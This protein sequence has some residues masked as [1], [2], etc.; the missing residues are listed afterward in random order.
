MKTLTVDDVMAMRPCPRWT[1]EQVKAVFAG[2]QEVAL[3]ALLADEAIPIGDRIWLALQPGVLPDAEVR[4]WLDGV[5]E[6]A[7]RANLGT[8]GCPKWETW[9]EKWLD[10]SDRS[11]ASAAR[12]AWTAATE[13]WRAARAAAARAAAAWAAARAAAAESR[14]SSR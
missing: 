3:D 2:R 1:R 4:A 14:P 5:V 10:G 6:R 8:S 7:I 11:E 9:A 13:A 12:A